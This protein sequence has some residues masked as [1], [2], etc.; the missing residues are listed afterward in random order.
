MQKYISVRLGVFHRGR[1]RFSIGFWPRVGDIAMKDF[2]E[3]YY[4]IKSAVSDWLEWYNRSMRL[5]SPIGVSVVCKCF[6]L[7]DVVCSAFDA[8]LARFKPTAAA[9]FE[10]LDTDGEDGLDG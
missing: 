2:P 6:E 3:L 8:Y 1:V 10:W 4:P 7:P 9:R 5:D